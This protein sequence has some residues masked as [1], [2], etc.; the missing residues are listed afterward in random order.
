M[1]GSQPASAGP[2]ERGEPAAVTE[3]EPPPPAQPGPRED[4]TQERLD[5]LEQN[6][7]DQLAASQATTEALSQVSAGL[8]V[9]TER[10]QATP[11]P[12]PQ[13]APPAPVQPAPPAVQPVAAPPPGEPQREATRRRHYA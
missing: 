6:Q 12:A 8:A 9:L 5:A 1:S 11:P 10:L 13:P 3:T 7:R 2:G 4:R